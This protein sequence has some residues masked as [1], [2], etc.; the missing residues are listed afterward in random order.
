MRERLRDA[1][2]SLTH[3]ARRRVLDI[4]DQ[5][6]DRLSAIFSL[7]TL[8]PSPE[9]RQLLQTW[10][11]KTI[12]L[13][14]SVDLSAG[15]VYKLLKSN[16]LNIRNGTDIGSFETFQRRLFLA[17]LAKLW[18]EFRIETSTAQKKRF[19]NSILSSLPSEDEKEVYLNVRKWTSAG[20]T[21]LGLATHLNGYGSLLLLP[22][23]I[24]RTL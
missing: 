18:Q 12:S 6:R 16:E 9:F 22:E 17:T 24:P 7:D 8:E 21:Y 20:M 11:N 13:S 2:A 3:S 23:S 19:A 1:S 4:I 15:A 14:N 5:K 10:A